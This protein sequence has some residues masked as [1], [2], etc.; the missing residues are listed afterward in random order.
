MWVDVKTLATAV[1]K[2][3]RTIQLMAKDGKIES[4]LA[5]KKALE[6][7]VPSLPAEWQDKVA[8]TVKA[9]VP[10]TK[11][12]A[13]LSLPAQLKTITT[14]TSTALALAAKL[15]DK[16]RERLLI[17]NKIKQR[18]AG[19]TKVKWLKTVARFYGVSTS[20]VRRIADDV[21]RYG[22]V[23]KPR[24]TSRNSVWDA[25]AIQFLTGF[26]LAAIRETGD[27][28]KVTA[29][30]RTQVVAKEKGWRI[31]SRSSAY[32]ILGRI[33]KLHVGYAKGGNRFL[34]NSFPI[35]RDCKALRPMQIIIGDQ[36]IFD[37]WIADYD[38]GLIR[39]PEC[40][41]WL[42]MGTKLI[43]GIAFDVHYCADTVREALRVG[44]RR[45]GRFECTYND[46]GSS[47]TS[48]AITSMIDDLLKLDMHA[49]DVA[50]LSKTP[51]GVYIVADA[52][53]NIVSTAINQ[54]DWRKQHRRIYANV[55]NAKAKDIERFFRTLNERLDARMLPGRCASPG[56]DSAVDE[57]ERARLEKQKN[58]HELLTEMEFIQVIFEELQAYENA[59]HGSLGMS[60]AAYL[61]QKI[62]GGWKPRQISE[63]AIELLVSERTKRVVRNGRVE[64]N[65]IWYWGEELSATNGE[66]NDVGLW[67]YHEQRVEVRYDK[68]DPS[69]A[70]AL[71]NG[72]ARYLEPVKANV[73]LDEQAMEEAIAAKRRQMKAVRD[74]FNALVKPIGSVLYQP[75]RATIRKIQ[76]EEYIEESDPKLQAA[77][78]KRLEDTRTVAKPIPFLALHASSYDRYRWCL[79]MLIRDI[80]LPMKDQAFMSSYERSDEYKNNKTYWEMYR[81][82]GGEA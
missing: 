43:Y 70:Y 81:K 33:S 73:M 42:D 6:I 18:P 75:Q 29:W 80:E 78:Q 63:Q 60:P 4:R 8:G 25:E 22:V 45:F 27:C 47:E 62:E 66:L 24:Q 35:Y 46:N 76:P 41:L 72:S 13:A 74:A 1:G 44:L 31:G 20:T 61:N 15:T 67:N 3:P 51:E 56:A 50:E 34:D 30:N 36:H 54:E 55:K 53:D 38:T 28:A 5:G 52:N 26:Y 17:A 37:H 64:I 49:E 48:K 69:H 12:L 40:Y 59:S 77:V 19:T 14:D 71:V 7:F 39:R 57:V 32:E 65:N 16:D 11:S 79:D 10:T 58:N 68:Y 21:N 2:S 23:G 9:V 82:L